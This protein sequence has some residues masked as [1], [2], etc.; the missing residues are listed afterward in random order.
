YSCAV[1]LSWQFCKGV[2]AH[3]LS[4]SRTTFC[5]CCYLVWV[6][7]RAAEACGCCSRHAGVPH[8]DA[9]ER[10]IRKD[11]GRNQ[12]RGEAY[13]RYLGQWCCH[14][15]KRYF[16]WRGYRV[17]GENWEAPIPLGD[18]HR[19]RAVEGWLS[20]HQSLSDA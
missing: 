20:V 18:S 5:A 14:P 13:G 8:N 6:L 11:F 9:T 19:F 10:G 17:R 1:A 12:D 4:L 3:V 2:K 15:P 7:A 16:F